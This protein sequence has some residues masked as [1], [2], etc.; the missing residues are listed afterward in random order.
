M[1][2]K[3]GGVTGG[4]T[5][6]APSA[7]GA[8]WGAGGGVGDAVKDVE[9]LGDGA[10]RGVDGDTIVEACGSCDDG[11]WGAFDETGRQP[12][13]RSNSAF[14]LKTSRFSAGTYGRC[15]RGGQCG[16]NKSV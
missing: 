5:D 9:A 15:A 11:G 2:N 3:W 6:V 1:A 13:L 4:K 14:W 12:Y 8:E 10:G 7:D 16:H